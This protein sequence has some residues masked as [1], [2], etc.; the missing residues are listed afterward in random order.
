MVTKKS[1]SKGTKK[2]LIKNNS[3]KSVKK[4]PTKAV[5]KKVSKQ[6]AKKVL[7]T[8]TTKRTIIKQRIVVTSGGF[9]P[10]HIG[11]VRLLNEAKKLG[12]KLIVILNNDNWIALKKGQPFMPQEERKEILEA[13]GSVDEVVYSS[14]KAGTKDMSIC[15][16]L[17]KLRPHVFAKGGDRHVGNIPEVAVCSAIG[18]EIVSDIGHGGKV[19]SSSWLISKAKER[20]EKKKKAANKK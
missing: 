13:L 7:V 16:D 3:K 1:V 4:N 18:C 10:I 20:A 15:E 9:D 19:Q 6:P 2:K 14:H 11:H 17:A 8:R 12:D 5:V